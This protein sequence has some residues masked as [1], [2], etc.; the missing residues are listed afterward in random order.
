[1]AD[2]SPAL[3]GSTRRPVA[4]SRT[5]GAPDPTASVDVT[6]VLRRRA[7][8]PADPAARMTREQLA[9]PPG[10][11]RP[12]STWS[13]TP[14]PAEGIEVTPS[15]PGPAGCRRA[16]TSDPRARVFGTTLEL[17]ESPAP[18]AAARSPTASAPASCP[19]PIALAG[20]VTAVLGLDDR[21]Q[22]RA[23]FRPAA[24]AA[25]RYTPPEL[26]H[27]LPLPDGTTG[28]GQTLAI[29]ELGGG[30]TQADL[31]AYWSTASA[32]PRRPRSPRSASTAA[33]N[34][35]GGRPERRRRR[36][37]ARHRG[38]RRARARRRRIVVYFAPNTD[39]GF[40]DALSTAVHAD[41]TPAAVS[42]SWGQSR[43]RVDR[44]GAHR[45]G[46]GHGRRRA[47]WASPSCVASGDD[48]SSDSATDGQA[49]VDFPA[50]SPHALGLRGH[51]AARRRLDRRGAAARRC[52]STASAGAAPAAA[53]A[54]SSPCPTW[55]DRAGVPGDADTGRPPAAACPTSPADADPATGYQV[56]VDGSDTVI[57]GT[58]AVAPLWAALVVPARRGRWAAGRAA[59]AA[60]VRRRR[61]AAAARRGSA[62]SPAAATAPTARQPAGTRAPGWASRRRGAAGQAAQRIRRLTSADVRRARGRTPGAARATVAA[63][64][65]I[66]QGSASALRVRESADPRT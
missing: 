39:R 13:A 33:T 58:S 64:P 12:T 22:S 30:Y 6:L 48:G 57:G 37:A 60:A 4:Q 40:L 21:P 3:P 62:T 50:S 36:G 59:A 52:G 25:T 65:N 46:R 29:M 10:P 2:D 11:T 53:S 24:A 17:V 18:P 44:P 5:A 35:P 32:W 56:R 20:V 19:S 26:A 41:P 9:A 61:R 49:H 66:R 47:R 28:A 14:S 1:M 16:A 15:T 23:R 34:A 54:T 43:G 38:G 45:D 27:G 7:P 42:I 63:Q 8:L 31:D 51:D 55:Q